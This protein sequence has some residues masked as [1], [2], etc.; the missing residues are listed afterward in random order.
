MGN[1]GSACEGLF[2]KT[3]AIG[4]SS[5]NLKYIQDKRNT[6]ISSSNFPPIIH[7]INHYQANLI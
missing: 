6:G 2:D 3:P 7:S 5:L 1:I 4:R